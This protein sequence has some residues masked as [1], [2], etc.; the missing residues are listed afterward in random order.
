VSPADGIFDTADETVDA[1]IT[2]LIP[3]GPGPH[4]VAVRAFD[5]AGNATVREVEA[6]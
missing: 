5:A 6:P 4:V 2:S 1:D 3:G